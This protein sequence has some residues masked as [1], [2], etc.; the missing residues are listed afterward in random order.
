LNDSRAI[1]ENKKHL[2]REYGKNVKGTC[3]I[4]GKEWDIRKYREAILGKHPEDLEKFLLVNDKKLGIVHE[5]CKD[6]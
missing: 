2:F 3:P 4:C 1:E 5:L 6:T